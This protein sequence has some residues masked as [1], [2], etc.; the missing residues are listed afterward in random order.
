MPRSDSEKAA[1]AHCR[2][3]ATACGPGKQLKE[4]LSAAYH[5]AAWFGCFDTSAMVQKLVQ[6]AG[7]NCNTQDPLQLAG[8]VAGAIGQLPWAML[9]GVI[10]GIPEAVGTCKP[11]D[12]LRYLPLRQQ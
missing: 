10:L 12:L 2:T 6:A 8:R 11:I 7:I 3:G 4:N 5:A 9:R 1:Q